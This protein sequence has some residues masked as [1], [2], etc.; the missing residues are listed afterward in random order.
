MRND[1]A[2]MTKSETMTKSEARRRPLEARLA[3]YA[4]RL[5][6][7]DLP[8]AVVREVKRRLVDS[9]GCAFGALKA[10]PC[11]GVIDLAASHGSERG[12]TLL[13]TKRRAPPDWAVFANGYLVQYLDYNDACLSRE[14]VHHPSGNI[15]AALAVAE[16]EG[17]DA[18]ELIVA[19]ALA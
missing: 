17:A 16:T 8:E 9:L 5:A 11:P 3:D 6:Y 1:E 18:R 7:K 2:R 10:G 12:A 15:P 19:I 4:A 14:R 13:G